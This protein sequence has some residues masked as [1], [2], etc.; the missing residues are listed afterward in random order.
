MLTKTLKAIGSRRQWLQDD[1]LRSLFKNAA[2]LFSGN[3][4]ASLLGLASLALTARALGVEQ[5]GFLVLITTY[6]LIVDRLVNFQSWQAIIKYGAD[7]LEQG[8]QED[9]KSLVKFGFLLDGAT[10]VLGAV[11]A[12]GS[13]WFVSHWRGWDDQLVLMAA[14]Y[15]FTILFNISGTPTAILRLFDK[16]KLVAYQSVISSAIKLVGVTIVFLSG[17]GLWAFLVVWAIVD[18]V[19]KIILVFFAGQELKAKGYWGFWGNSAKAISQKFKGIWG[20]V[21]TTNIHSSVKLGLREGDIMLVGAL[22]GPVGAG[23]YKIV[24]TIGSTMGKVTDPL[25]QAAYPDISR[26]VSAKN[27]S[28]IR[29]LILRT[30]KIIFIVA[31]A[32]LCLFFVFGES[33]IYTLLGSDYVEAFI[34]SLVYLMGT[35]IA[36]ITFTFQPTVLAFGKAHLSLYILTIATTAYLFILSALIVPYGLVGAAISFVLFYLIWAGMQVFLICRLLKGS[37]V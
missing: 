3:M 34:P 22:I 36:M 20:F 4:V 8:R 30:S 11:I 23:L 7:A 21:W 12:A 24:K 1:L 28:S 26:A 37:E 33:A 19:G 2:V 5:F 17:A 10:A 29:N 13:A 15:S 9:F 6:V 31:I 27:Y 16:F 25:Y 35:F 32:C 14:L 18:I